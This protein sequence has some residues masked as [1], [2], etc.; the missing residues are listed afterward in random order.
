M[1]PK[2]QPTVSSWI[3]PILHDVH[4]WV[5]LVALAIGALILY[6]VQ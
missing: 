5:P 6:S 3:R 2:P 1:H 4:F